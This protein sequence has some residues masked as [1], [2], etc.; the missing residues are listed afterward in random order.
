MGLLLPKSRTLFA[1]AGTSDHSL[2]TLCK[3]E[4]FQT[5]ASQCNATRT[6]VHSTHIVTIEILLMS[7]LMHRRPRTS[8]QSADC[9]FYIERLLENQGS[10]FSYCLFN[11]MYTLSSKRFFIVQNL[12]CAW[13]KKYYGLVPGLRELYHGINIQKDMRMYVGKSRGVGCARAGA[14]QLNCNENN[15]SPP[16]RASES[17]KH[18]D[19]LFVYC[20][21]WDYSPLRICLQSIF[22]SRH[23]QLL[24]AF[25][26]ATFWNTNPKSPMHTLMEELRG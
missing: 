2:D 23:R 17:R 7:S 11:C 9:Q 14:S 8:N 24:G 15:S 19:F 16:T 20:N 13:S 22:E 26:S 1:I 21:A 6:H 12:S 5:L 25:M 4:F 18:L 3:L 10:V